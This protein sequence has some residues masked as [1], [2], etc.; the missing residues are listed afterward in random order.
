M[1][2]SVTIHGAA[3]AIVWGYQ[4]AALVRGWRIY[5]H[6][7][8]PAHDGKWRLTATITRVDKVMIRRR[9]LLFTAP[10]DRG[11]WCWPLEPTSVQVGDTT[12]VAILGPPEQ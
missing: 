8:D 4:E 6:R 1:F 9:R 5:Y 12:L 11:R 10:R 3:G 7:P 2:E